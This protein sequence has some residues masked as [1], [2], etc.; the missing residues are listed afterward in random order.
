MSELQPGMLALVVGCRKDPKLVGSIIEVKEAIE[1]RFPLPD[2]KD[3]WDRNGYAAGDWVCSHSM[4]EFA[5]A[6]KHL[7]AI[8]PESDPLDVT[9]KEE[10]HA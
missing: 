10:L 4:G 6:T 2:R 1:V 3:A 8:K 7:K 9:H 5:I